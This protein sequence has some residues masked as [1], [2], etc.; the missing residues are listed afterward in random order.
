MDNQDIYYDKYIKYKT[1]YLE[2]KEQSGGNCPFIASRIPY[3]NQY[4]IFDVGLVSINRTHIHNNITVQSGPYPQNRAIDNNNIYINKINTI[5]DPLIIIL[6]VLIKKYTYFSVQ[7]PTARYFQTILNYLITLNSKYNDF[8]KSINNAQIYHDSDIKER[9]NNIIENNN[10]KKFYDDESLTYKN[11]INEIEKNIKIII[12]QI[13]Q[14]DKS[15]NNSINTE[16]NKNNDL[17]NIIDKQY[18]DKGI[19]TL[20]NIITFYFY[21]ILDGLEFSMP[22][23]KINIK[24][25]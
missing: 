23:F 14:D 11:K 1:K 20:Q 8:F 21:K 9:D 6:N 12:Q 16:I 24:K 17:K 5:H 10:K 13:K 19:C 2:L 4:E 18:Y 25:K 15:L 7:G 22:A 3:V